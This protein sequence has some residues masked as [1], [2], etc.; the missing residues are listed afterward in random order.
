[1]SLS[2]RAL[3]GAGFAALLPA[4]SRAG[5]DEPLRAGEYLR[6]E[7]YGLR[8]Q[9]LAGE[10]RVPADGPVDLGHYG[11]LVVRGRTP[12][13]VRAELSACVSGHRI[14]TPAEPLPMLLVER[15]PAPFQTVYLLHA[16]SAYRT[17]AA[18]QQTVLGLILTL[19][20]QLVRERECRLHIRS[21]LGLVTPVNW[22]GLVETGSQRDNFRL[23][24]GD[25]VEIGYS[26]P[27]RR[28]YCPDFGRP[29]HPYA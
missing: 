4:V 24:D 3:L 1:M 20:P 21:Q 28:E 15:S 26:T 27:R 8:R 7:A 18:G 29:L 10:F 5:A 11:A 16:D 12:T 2:R 19:R 17:V 9:V 6:I 23:C 25:H 14:S 22:R 13:Q